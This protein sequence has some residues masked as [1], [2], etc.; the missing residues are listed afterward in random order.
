MV[1]AEIETIATMTLGRE[2]EAN[3]QAAI[4]LIRAAAIHAKVICFQDGNLL[5]VGS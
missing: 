2:I 4:I 1:E 5:S 3:S